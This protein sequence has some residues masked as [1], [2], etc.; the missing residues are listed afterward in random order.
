MFDWLLSPFLQYG[1]MQRA[2]FGSIVLSISCAP[3]GVFLMLRRMSLT[4]D[5]MSHGADATKLLDVEMNEFARLLPLIAADWFGRL[6]GTELIEPSPS[7]N[8]AD[9]GGRDAEFAGDLLS[10]VALSAQSLD[11]VAGGLGSLAV[12]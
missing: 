10:S 3:V 5:A 1:F 9:G 11:R 6:Q 2:L 4:G 12:R 7:Q 8:A